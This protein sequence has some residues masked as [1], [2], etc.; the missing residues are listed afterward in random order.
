MDDHPLAKIYIPVTGF[1][2]TPK[3]CPYPETSVAVYGNCDH[4]AEIVK[5]STVVFLVDSNVGLEQAQKESDWRD[6][7]M[8]KTGE[9]PGR[10]ATRER[11]L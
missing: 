6:G 2:R 1:L 3:S 10:W 8:P 9:E 4:E 5:P 11:I 7:S